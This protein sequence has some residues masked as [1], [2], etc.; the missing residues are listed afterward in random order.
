MF[1]I[2]IEFGPCQEQHCQHGGKCV[3]NLEI[4]PAVATCICAQG[5]EGPNCETGN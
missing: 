2:V 1:Y 5:F 4:T 3:A